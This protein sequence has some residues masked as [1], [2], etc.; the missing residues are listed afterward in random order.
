MGGLSGLIM[1]DDSPRAL[2]LVLLGRLK[3]HRFLGRRGELFTCVR[4]D[5]TSDSFRT[6]LASPSASS[7]GSNSAYLKREYCNICARWYHDRKRDKG[8]T[9]NNSMSRAMSLVRTCD[10]TLPTTASDSLRS[11]SRRSC[12]PPV[13]RSVPLHLL[14]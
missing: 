7:E 10:R 2:S 6:W 4:S 1:E 9:W 3:N 14:F 12:Y 8:L 5:D 13:T 11:T